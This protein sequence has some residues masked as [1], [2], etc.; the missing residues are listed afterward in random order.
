MLAGQPHVVRYIETFIEAGLAYI[1]M[2]QCDVTLRD[3]LNSMPLVNE[4]SLKRA[5]R[6]M[7]MGLAWVHSARV[8]HSDVKPDNFLCRGQDLSVKLCDFGVASKLPSGGTGLLTGVHGTPPYMAPEMLWDRGFDTKADTWSMGVILYGLLL[9]NYP[10][11]PSKMNSEGMKS[12]IMSG[13]PAPNFKSWPGAPVSKHAH[14]LIRQLLARSP[15][16]RLG[17]P[18]A[19]QHP[20]FLSKPLGYPLKHLEENDNHRVVL[21]HAADVG[22]FHS[23]CGG[24]GDRRQRMDLDLHLA[25]LQERYRASCLRLEIDATKS[26]SSTDLGS[27]DDLSTCRTFSKSSSLTLT[28]SR[29]SS[30]ARSPPKMFGAAPQD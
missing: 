1:V 20:F 8:V 3:A 19:L 4:V 15:E 24:V 2:E 12:T 21:Q 29:S 13:I 16:S 27:I 30:K 26:E 6:E 10:Y 18:G 25:S 17:A 11:V 23:Q 28:P 9:G 7:L 14:H 5:F 22:F